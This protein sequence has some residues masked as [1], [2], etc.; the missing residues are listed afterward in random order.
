[1]SGFNVMYDK[2]HTSCV[3]RS[4]HVYMTYIHVH[5]YIHVCMYMH[6]CVHI[7]EASHVMQPTCWDKDCM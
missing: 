2:Y 6:V 5:T 4:T 3:V 1:M 7:H